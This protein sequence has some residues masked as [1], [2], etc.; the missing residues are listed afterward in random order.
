[1]IGLRVLT[2][3]YVRSYATNKFGTVYGNE[4][5]FTTEN[6]KLNDVD[7]NVYHYT[8]IGTQVWMVE[9]LK[10][11]RYRNGDFI[12]PVTDIA[13][14]SRLTIGT[15]AKNAD[16]YGLFYNG[17]A[18]K[19]SRN[20]APKGWHIPSDE[21]W[22]T[23][24]TYLGGAEVAGGKLKDTDS[25][26]WNSPNDVASYSCGFSALP[27]G[28]FIGAGLNFGNTGYWW[29]STEKTATSLWFRS[30]QNISKGISRNVANKNAGYSVRC[31]RD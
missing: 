9:D 21:E 16:A 20:L 8:N 7:G 18:V 5:C 10:T 3:Y 12:E 29:T 28:F 15:F 26:R 11:K 30:L 14:W 2:K 4:V 31:V 24:V 6:G 17:Y 1:M 19:D 25:L 13:Q 23:L 22:N 27:N